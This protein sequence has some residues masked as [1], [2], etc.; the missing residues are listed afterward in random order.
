MELNKD[1][2]L[3]ANPLFQS[4]IGF[5]INWSEGFPCFVGI[6]QSFNP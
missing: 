1:S 5:K 6:G 4:L 3:I 2:P